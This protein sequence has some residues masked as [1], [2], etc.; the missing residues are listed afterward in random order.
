[1][2][3]DFPHVAK[4]KTSKCLSCPRIASMISVCRQA[5]QDCRHGGSHLS[6]QAVR[7]CPLDGLPMDFQLELVGYEH[8][9]PSLVHPF[10]WYCCHEECIFVDVSASERKGPA[11]LC[12]QLHLRCRSHHIQYPKASMCQRKAQLDLKET[13]ELCSL[14]TCLLEDCRR[15][16]PSPGSALPTFPTTLASFRLKSS[17]S[18]GGWPCGRIS[19]ARSAG[20]S[21]RWL[22]SARAA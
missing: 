13:L 6:R 22:S 14:W 5:V 3:A 1:M 10:R 7:H 19:S 21:S 15:S 17:L 20:G 12:L 2:A 9:L 18:I 8:L 11:Q 4:G 16:R